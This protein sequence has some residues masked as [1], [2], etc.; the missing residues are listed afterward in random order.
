MTFIPPFF[1]ERKKMNDIIMY[2]EEHELLKKKECVHHRR[3][4]PNFIPVIPVSDLKEQL[5]KIMDSDKSLDTGYNVLNK[6]LK[7]LGG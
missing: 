2:V 7:S 6:L 5:R 4:G 1:S 3:W